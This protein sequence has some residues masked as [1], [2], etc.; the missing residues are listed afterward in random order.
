MATSRDEKKEQFQIPMNGKWRPGVD[1]SQQGDGDFQELT[2]LRYTEYQSV[3]PV[4]GMTK[5]NSTPLTDPLLKTGIQFRKDSSN[6]EH[7]LVQAFNAGGTQGKIYDNATAS[8]GTG[9][10][11][12]TALF[13]ETASSL[14]GR[15]SLAPDGCV[16]FA[17]GK[18]T[19]LWGGS[20]YRVAA[21]I[22][23][24]SSGI[25]TT[26]GD[27]TDQVNNTKTDAANVATLLDVTGVTHL[28]IGTTR[29]TQ[30]F[31][32]YVGTPN[33]AASTLVSTDVHYWNGSAWTHVSSFLDG[34]A[35][36]G[37]TLAKTGSLSYTST[38]GLAIPLVLNGLYL[39][40]HY[41]IITGATAGTTISR[42]T[43]NDP[44]QPIVDLWDGTPRYV[45]GCYTSQG[46]Q[47]TNV[48]TKD[49]VS[50]DNTTIINLGAMTSISLGFSQRITAMQFGIVPGAGNSNAITITAVKYHN[51]LT[52]AMTSVGTLVDS[53]LSGGKSLA[54]TGWVSWNP[55][56]EVNEGPKTDPFSNPMLYWYTVEFGAC[57]ANTSLDY[58]F[59]IPAQK[60]LSNY[61]FPVFWQNRLVL[62]GEVDGK[63]NSL[64]VGGF[65][66]SCRFNGADSLSIEDLGDDSLPT[67]AG[68]IFTRYTGSF[69][70]TLIICKSNEVWVL[71]GTDVSNYHLY[72]VS[73]L[74]GCNA[75]ETFRILPVNYEMAPGIG[76]HVAI[77]QS[78]TGVV[79]FDGNT[80]TPID[81]DIKNFY[82][83]AH[84]D[85]ILPVNQSKSTAFIDE[86]EREYHLII[87]YGASGTRREIV[88]NTKK[89]GWFD[90]DRGTVGI[91]FG[92]PLGDSNGA[93]YTYG[94]TNTGYLERLENGTTFDGTPITTSFKTKDY[95]YA[96][97]MYQTQLSN[98]KLITKSKASGSATL[99]H[100]GDG[101]ISATTERAPFL[102]SLVNSLKRLV[103]GRKALPTDY[104]TFHS[105]R[106]T[107]T[108]STLTPGFEPIGIGGFWKSP[109]REEQ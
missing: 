65:G 86:R 11:T 103:F 85:Y 12:A 62:I 67:A 84:A 8:P 82:D 15:W 4:L 29:P 22:F 16:A 39:Y 35:V 70:D 71:D 90:L 24:D 45:Q 109:P 97:W 87:Y 94:L 98:I 43:V 105:F 102:T 83:P 6:E 63:K 26:T 72:K 95:C 58:V 56:D 89:K 81:E 53:T 19:C 21:F 40:W 99:T 74:Y 3:K 60:K 23:G 49:Y 78:A 59:A 69:Y 44:F 107:S 33:S 55:P 108:S 7:L 47:V 9:D 100:F 77:W 34:T 73:E 14:P 79:L 51:R 27:F 41:I 52:N 93:R 42:C 36:A 46:D 92:I 50:G 31:K 61:R 17:N 101:A 76:R 37:K 80:L 88:Y 30:G 96:G 57:S 54:Q 48:F 38:V 2:N 64:L 32:F 10:F 25:T 20:E 104:H 66:S 18:E 68:A 28:F 5:I 1:G 91:N 75:G 13:T 106:A